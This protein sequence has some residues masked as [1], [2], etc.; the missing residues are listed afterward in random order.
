MKYI[1]LNNLDTTKCH[2]RSSSS[3]LSVTTSHNKT[4][5]IVRRAEK[6]EKM[7]TIKAELQ[8]LLQF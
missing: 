7:V 1:K 8:Y 6:Q 4:P 5:N 3:I 2:D